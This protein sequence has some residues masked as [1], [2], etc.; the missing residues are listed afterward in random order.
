MFEDQ[1]RSPMD[2]WFL[3]HEIEYTGSGDWLCRTC[4]QDNNI[5]AWK[6][7]VAS[8]EAIQ[9][10]LI[11]ALEKIEDVACVT[12]GWNDNCDHECVRLA[13]NVLVKHRLGMWKDY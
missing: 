13:R 8:L 3:Y 9:T 5:K 6:D 1:R 11:E 4:I 10:D 12:V 7:K 2:C